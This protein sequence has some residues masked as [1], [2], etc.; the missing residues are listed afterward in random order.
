MLRIHEIKAPIGA[1]IERVRQAAAQMVGICAADLTDFE[2]VK[3]SV[4][5][6]KKNNIRM[7]YTVD[8]NFDGDLEAVARRFPS[9]QCAVVETYE[10][11]LPENRRHSKFRPVV[12]G[13]GPAG[14]LCAYLL[15]KAG[16][17]P[18]VLERGN[19]VDARQADVKRFWA[20]RVLDTNSNVQFGEGGAGTFS[21]GKLT[22]GIKDPRVREVFEVFLRHGAPPEIKY[23]ARPHI[24]TDK[25]C[26]MVKNMRMEILRMGGEVRF[27]AR[28]QR[29]I[30]ANEFVHG[31]SYV[32]GG[33]IH[34]LETDCVALCIG[35]S[36]RD[37]FEML[38]QS[39]VKMAQKAFSVGTRIEHPQEFINRS[40]YGRLWNHPLL[41]AADYKLSNHPIHGRGGYTFCM[42][43]GGYVVTASSEEGMVVVNGMSEYAR[44]GENANSAILVGIEPD[45]FADGHPLTGIAFQREIERAAFA[46][47]GQSY[48]APAQTVGDFLKNIPSR[49]LGAVNPTCPTGVVPGDIRTVLPPVVT[50]TIQ[51]AL[52]NFDTKI[53]GF[54]M[55]DAVLTA[56]ESRSSSPVRI[57]RDEF[58]QSN[59]RGL[60][61]CGEGAGYAGGIVSAATDGIRVAEAILGDEDG[62]FND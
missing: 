35:H 17:N 19:D 10:Y 44:D 51:K 9:N 1:D 32:Q 16:H 59:V 48:A 8:I 41:P 29:L 2:I 20:E 36:A 14:M 42:C 26:A 55:A 28:F 43:P 57:L 50:D 23:S 56:P 22:T 30:A 62:Y 15:A 5:S 37:T 49:R 61:P 24:G 21:D 45:Y 34:D 27:G 46:A 3:E 38:Y 54:A 47:G 4:D 33:R 6:R 13:F 39:G 58:F 52:R 25:L 53:Q 7:V 40:Q 18:I 12:V 31:L 11:S 60:Y